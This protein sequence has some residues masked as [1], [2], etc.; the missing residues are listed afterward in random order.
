[1]K[2]RC[3][4]HDL[5]SSLQITTRAISSRSTQPILEGVL[6]EALEDGLK[7]TA[8]DGSFT[9]VT[10]VPATVELEGE[11][12]LPGKKN[13]TRARQSALSEKRRLFA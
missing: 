3:N 1:M 9:S 7:L 12:V 2:F 13:N 11:A 5:L 4:S 8:S 6:V 10:R